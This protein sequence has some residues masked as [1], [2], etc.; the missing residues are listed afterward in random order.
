MEI[1]ASRASNRNMRSREFINGITFPSQNLFLQKNETNNPFY[2]VVGVYVVM[3]LEVGSFNSLEYV[4]CKP[5][6][7]KHCAFRSH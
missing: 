3:K 5:P 6:I 7:D 2:R 4:L 1:I